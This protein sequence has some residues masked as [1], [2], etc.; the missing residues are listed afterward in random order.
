MKQISCERHVGG[1]GNGKRLAIVQGLELGQLID[2]L[3]DQITDLP[4]DA[5]PIGRGHARPRTVLERP[6]RRSYGPVDVLGVTF[7]DGGETVACRRVRSDE[8]AARRGVDPLTVN[9]QLTLCRD[10]VV[11]SLIERDRHGSPF[12]GRPPEEV[13]PSRL[14]DRSDNRRKPHASVVGFRVL[15]SSLHR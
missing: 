9:E 1:L 15:D 8:C 6:P 2:V 5:A 11:D 4:D 12:L 14:S 3:E 10:E 13:R 7:G